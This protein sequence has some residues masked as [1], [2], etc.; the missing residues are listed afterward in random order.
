MSRGRYLCDGFG[1]ITVVTGYLRDVTRGHCLIF[2]EEYSD[3]ALT[4]PV[5]ILQSTQ[6]LPSPVVHGARSQRHTN[7]SAYV[8]LRHR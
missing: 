6:Y 7:N 2:A 8:Y 4:Q 3:S 5:Q 1:F